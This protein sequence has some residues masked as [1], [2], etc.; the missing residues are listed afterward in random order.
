LEEELSHPRLLIALVVHW[1][2]VLTDM[3]EGLGVLTVPDNKG[4]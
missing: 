2:Y 4:F 1:H 3:L